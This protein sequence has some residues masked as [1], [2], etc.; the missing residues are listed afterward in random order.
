MTISLRT[1]ADLSRTFSFF[2]EIFSELSIHPKLDSGAQ[3]IVADFTLALWYLSAPSSDRV[4]FSSRTLDIQQCGLPEAHQL[5]SLHSETIA[6]FSSLDPAFSPL[7]ELP[8]ALSAKTPDAALPNHLKPH[9][10]TCVYNIFN[11]HNP[12]PR[13]EEGTFCLFF[14]RRGE[15]ALRFPS[16]AH[17]DQVHSYL[18]SYG[19]VCPQKL[20][21][22]LRKRPNQP[23]YPPFQKN[24]DGLTPQ[25]CPDDPHT[26][27]FPT[28]PANGDGLT[29][30]FGTPSILQNF[31]NLFTDLDIVQSFGYVAR[32]FQP[33][34]L[35]RAKNGT[36]IFST[37][38]APHQSVYFSPT[39]LTQTFTCAY[40]PENLPM[41]AAATSENLLNTHVI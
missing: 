40:L 1:Q 29:C 11:Q 31:L 13:P 2:K 17:R 32:L 24:L 12:T 9:A 10:R 39:V 30:D 25:L 21:L 15:L 34:T 19:K 20:G 6:S 36:T 37:D 26:I 14:N 7:A 4:G 23:P 5:I 3:L 41:Q 38:C 35:Y 16:Q 22:W 27:F 28:Y 8:L 33:P 18:L